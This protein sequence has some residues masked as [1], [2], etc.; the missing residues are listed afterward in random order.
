[1]REVIEK[2]YNHNNIYCIKY[3]YVCVYSQPRKDKLQ[4]DTAM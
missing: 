2:H 3:M 1:M 4:R